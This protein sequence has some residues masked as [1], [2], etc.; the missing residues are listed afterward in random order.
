MEYL[1]C[2]GLDAIWARTVLLTTRLKR[3]LNE[4]PGVRLITPL[5]PEQS[6]AV[7]GFNLDDWQPPHVRDALRKRWRIVVK[8]FNTTR[9]GLRAS[10]PFFLLEEE[11][12][13]LLHALATLASEG[14]GLP[15]ADS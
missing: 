10:V 11:I 7:V 3:G 13:L 6:A 9:Q 2:I 5:S 1:T 4:I 14:P 8:A 12:D 15:T